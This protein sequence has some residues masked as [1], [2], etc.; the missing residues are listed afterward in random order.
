MKHKNQRV[1][2]NCFRTYRKARGLKQK[3]V[4]D[5]LG[6]K[7]TSMISRWENGVC[8]PDTL[9]LLKL[10]VLYRRLVDAL[11][12]D[13]IRQ[14]REELLQREEKVLKRIQEKTKRGEERQTRLS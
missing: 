5:I 11:V 10:A 8:L 13:I 1:K 12:I 6:L 14:L 9:N 7:S 4:A 2:I 3:E